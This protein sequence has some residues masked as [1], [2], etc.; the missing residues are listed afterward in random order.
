[1]VLGLCCLASPARGV[2]L[3][4]LDTDY[5]S[6][7]DDVGALATLH[8]F[9]D[10]GWARILGVVATTTGPH[11][12][13]AIDAVNTFYGRTNIPVGLIAEDSRFNTTLG[14]DDYAPLLADRARFPSERTNA[15]AP[16]STALYRRLLNGAADQSVTIV[17]VG[18][19]TAVHR[20]L[21]SGSR[22]G[23]DDIAQTGKELVRRK[24]RELVLMG[25]HFTDPGFAEFNITLDVVAAQEIAGRW[26][27]PI[28]YSGFER[29]VGVLTG[30]A[31]R[32]PA[33]HPVALAY[34]A[35]R[36]SGGAGVIGNRSSWDQTAVVYAVVGTTYLGRPLWHRSEAH[37]I[38]FTDEGRT[39][40]TVDPGSDRYYLKEGMS[41]AD[42]AARISGWMIRPPGVTGR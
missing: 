35:Y 10:L 5:R 17:V 16:E 39:L 28:M 12:V 29:G 32:D 9:E 25:G 6:D 37:R 27:S 2:P 41:D 8:A 21:R 18:A 3:V 7:V 33:G 11:V 23:G 20:L 30:A 31:L 42:V 14:D 38:G 19:Q 15:D 1:M 26:P 34:E 22:H 36:G 13:A 40:R 4:I 24:V